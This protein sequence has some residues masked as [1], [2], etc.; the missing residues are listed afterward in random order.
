MLKLVGTASV[1]MA[2]NKSMLVSEAAIVAVVVY[3]EEI[4]DALVTVT[5]EEET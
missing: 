1:A 2:W 4:T 3:V 5:V